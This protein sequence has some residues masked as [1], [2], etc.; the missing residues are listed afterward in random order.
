MWN[1]YRVTELGQDVL[2]E[3]LK[4]DYPEINRILYGPP[5]KYWMCRYYTDTLNEALAHYTRG[6][7]EIA[8]HIQGAMAKHLKGHERENALNWLRSAYKRAIEI[9]KDR[10]FEKM[11]SR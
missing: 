1:L 9:G 4:E 8:E 11:I 6:V 3:M 5:R 10:I 2:L 7:K